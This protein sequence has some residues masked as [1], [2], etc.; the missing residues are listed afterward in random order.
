[1]V[2]LSEPSEP[3]KSAL[4]RAWCLETAWP[5]M[6]VSWTKAN[7]AHAQ[8][9][10]TSLL[11][12]DRCG[13]D[14]VM[15]WVYVPET[16]DPILHFFNR[17]DDRD[18]DLTWLQFPVGSRFEELDLSASENQTLYNECM[19]NQDTQDRYKLLTFLTSVRMNERCPQL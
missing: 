6:R 16:S 17:I 11:V 15:G 5:P 10:V 14:L 4:S 13:G 19:Q 2:L 9:L 3:L 1:M 12:Q 7:P 8:C 18:Y